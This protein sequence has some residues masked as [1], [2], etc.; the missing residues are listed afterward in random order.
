[1]ESPDILEAEF[2]VTPVT[3]V[4]VVGLA[5]VDFQVTAESLDTVVVEFPVTVDS[6]DTLDRQVILVTRVCQD[7][8]V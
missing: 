6:P 2:L 7:I 8:Q 4:S 3:A 5:T 1:M